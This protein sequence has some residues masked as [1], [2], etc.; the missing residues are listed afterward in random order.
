MLFYFGESAHASAHVNATLSIWFY[1]LSTAIL[2][3]DVYVCMA[4]R[5]RCTSSFFQCPY[6][7]GQIGQFLSSNDLLKDWLG[8]KDRFAFPHATW[9]IWIQ[10]VAWLVDRSGGRVVKVLACGA[11]GPGFDSRPRHLNFQ[12]LVISCFQV[13]IWLKCRWSDVNPRQK[14]YIQLV[15]WLALDPTWQLHKS[16]G[17]SEMCHC[18]RKKKKIKPQCNA[19]ANYLKMKLQD[20]QVQ[21][22]P[23]KNLSSASCHWLLWLDSAIKLNS[24]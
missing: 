9:W 20:S 3:T 2:R 5:L 17:S 12:R 24:E 23:A 13:A 4:V 10:L 15:A 14:K 22:S 8:L 16:N 21:E 19:I 11:R 6:L 18:T 1:W 7:G